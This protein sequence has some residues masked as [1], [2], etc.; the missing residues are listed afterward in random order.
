MAACNNVAANQFVLEGAGGCDLVFDGLELAEKEE[1]LFFVRLDHPKEMLAKP[2]RYE[3]D[4]L[5]ERPTE[6]GTFEVAS[7]QTVQIVVAADGKKNK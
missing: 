3:I 6:E 1:Y 7:G 2:Q 5:Y 4:V